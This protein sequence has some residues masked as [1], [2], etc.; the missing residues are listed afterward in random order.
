M[1]LN[2]Y[3]FFFFLLLFT[4]ETYMCTILGI[5]TLYYVVKMAISRLL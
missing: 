2:I 1:A 4:Q 3:L 5:S